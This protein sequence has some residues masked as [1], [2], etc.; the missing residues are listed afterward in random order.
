M[1]RKW[2]RSPLPHAG[3]NQSVTRQRAVVLTTGV[4]SGD[5]VADAV[6]MPGSHQGRLHLDP[7][8]GAGHGWYQRRVPGW[9]ACQRVSRGP[10]ATA[11]RWS[12]AMV[13][14]GWSRRSRWCGIC[15]NGRLDPFRCQEASSEPGSGGVVPIFATGVSM[16]RNEPARWSS[17]ADMAQ[18]RS[19]SQ[20]CGC[21]AVR[22]VRLVRA[23][24]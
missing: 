13:F 23:G 11:G 20:A 16:S 4:I 6:G 5:P 7:A 19:W 14:R 2:L 12:P 10:A 15:S 3:R 18:G 21:K 1:T 9:S 17:P 24:L 8:F 22:I